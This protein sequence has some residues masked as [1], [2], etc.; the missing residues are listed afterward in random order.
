MKNVKNRK[1]EKT[2]NCKN[3]PKWYKG[4]HFFHAHHLCQRTKKKISVA[5]LKTVGWFLRNHC[6]YEIWK[7]QE[8][9]KNSISSLHIKKLHSKGGQIKGVDLTFQMHTIT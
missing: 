9:L 7:D 5:K 8:K 3:G 1:C 6:W 2:E 4:P